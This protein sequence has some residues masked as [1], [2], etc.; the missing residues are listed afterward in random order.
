M[1]CEKPAFKNKEKIN[2][3]WSILLKL[4]KIMCQLNKNFLSCQDFP[5]QVKIFNLNQPGVT[6]N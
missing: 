1:H 6:L 2:K 3:N 5:E 4:T